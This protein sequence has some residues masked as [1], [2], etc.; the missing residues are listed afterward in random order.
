MTL[1][2]GAKTEQ[3]ICSCIESGFDYVRDFQGTGIFRKK[4]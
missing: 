3:E 1:V 4:K 2:R